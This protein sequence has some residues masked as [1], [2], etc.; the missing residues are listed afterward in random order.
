MINEPRIKFYGIIVAIVVGL[1]VLVSLIPESPVS[2]EKSRTEQLR[3]F[4]V[5]N[6]QWVEFRNGNATW[7][8][9][10]LDYEGK[11]VTCRSINNQIFHGSGK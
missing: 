10:L 9:A 11:P 1:W 4:C 5:M 2:L 8:T 7:G 3:T 6:R